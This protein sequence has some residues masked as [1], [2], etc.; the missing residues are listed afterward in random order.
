MTSSATPGPR[1]P[2]SGEAPATRPEDGGG[3][4]RGRMAT[5]EFT[6]VSN[7]LARDEK[8]SN[9]AKG[10]FVQMASHT[11]GF[12]I[13]LEGMALNCADGITAVRSALK[14]LELHGYVRRLPRVRDMKGHLGPYGYEITDVPES[15]RLSVVLA[16]PAALDAEK[17]GT[18]RSRPVSDFPTLVEPVEV[19]LTTKKTKVKKT[20][21]VPRVPPP[22][23][24]GARLLRRLQL[25]HPITESTVAR[26]AALVDD[27]LVTWPAEALLEY[28]ELECNAPGVRKPIG[29]LVDVLRD[30]RPRATRGRGDR[31]A[32]NSPQPCG[33]CLDPTPGWIEVGSKDHIQVLRCPGC[34]PGPR[35]G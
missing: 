26:Y 23:T 2:A 27:L 25:R 8:L 32:V 12:R 31:D 7:R 4:L 30:I 35:A 1:R 16:S 6:M 29:R 9:S 20:D 17:A 3:L 5:K 28:L 15:P 33:T 13:T 10:L 19:D 21:Q 24:A 18:P 14:E 22:D 34:N 11:E